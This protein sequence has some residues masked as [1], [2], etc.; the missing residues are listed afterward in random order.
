MYLCALLSSCRPEG[1]IILNSQLSRERLSRLSLSLRRGGGLGLLL[2]GSSEGLS[3]QVLG[4]L[5][6][7]RLLRLD[8]VAADE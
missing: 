8:L 3:N 1:L 7:D 2:L 5:V 4:S 6:R